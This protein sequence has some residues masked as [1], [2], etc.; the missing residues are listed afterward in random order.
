M[1]ICET[2]GVEFSVADDE[3]IS[4]DSGDLCYDCIQAE[5]DE[6]GQ[7]YGPGGYSIY[8]AYD[9]GSPK[10]LALNY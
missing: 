9:V 2:C 7:L 4:N 3:G 1:E 6:M 8:D 5:E 10:I